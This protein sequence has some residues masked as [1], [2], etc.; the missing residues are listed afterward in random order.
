M[1]IIGTESIGVHRLYPPVCP[2]DSH[3]NATIVLGDLTHLT[4]APL[5]IPKRIY[6][7]EVFCDVFIHPFIHSF[8]Q[9]F[10]QRERGC[11]MRNNSMLRT[12]DRVVGEAGGLVLR[13]ELI[14][15]GKEEWSIWKRIMLWGALT[16]Y[17]YSKRGKGYLKDHNLPCQRLP[18][19]FFPAQFISTQKL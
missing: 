1:S 5:N 11:A 15:R 8:P 2:Y 6:V 10:K 19:L 13:V 7:S 14:V 12:C 9:Q 3:S 18:V 16:A 17:T 4:T